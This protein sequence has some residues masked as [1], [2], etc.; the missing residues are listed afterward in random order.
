MI[1]SPY[2]IS[3]ALSFGAAAGNTQYITRTGDGIL[4]LSGV[5]SGGGAGS[6]L[7]LNAAAGEIRLTGTANTFTGTVTIAVYDKVW[8]VRQGA[9]AAC[10]HNASMTTAASATSV[11]NRPSSL[12]SIR[13]VPFE[14]ATWTK[15]SSPSFRTMN[16]F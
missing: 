2:T 3:S 16:Q 12:Y 8:Y 4:T 10:S 11:W 5:L 7:Y 13:W 15:C 6:V 14:R 1:E 9:P